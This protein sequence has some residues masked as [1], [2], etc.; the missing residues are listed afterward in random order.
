MNA[1]EE[2]RRMLDERGVE[3]EDCSNGSTYVEYEGEAWRF[4]PDGYFDA[5]CIYHYCSYTPEQAVDATLGR[6]T[7]RLEDY[8]D[9]GIY[10]CSECGAV[11]PEDFMAYYCWSYCPNCG[12]KVVEA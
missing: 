3:W 8:E 2:L 10:V 12:A 9:T 11:A 7:C 6:G 4:D 5:L 1:T